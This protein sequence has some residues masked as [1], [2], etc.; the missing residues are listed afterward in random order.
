MEHAPWAE[1]PSKATVPKYAALACAESNA[2]LVKTTKQIMTQWSA[3]QW[4]ATKSKEV[5]R[6]MPLL[7]AVE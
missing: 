1:T 7:M 5:D 4:P 3:M 2:N 6:K